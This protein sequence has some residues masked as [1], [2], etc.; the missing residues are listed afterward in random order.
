M[1]SGG[2][3]FHYDDSEWNQMTIP[4]D[5]EIQSI[6]G[7]SGSDVYAVGV[8]PSWGA[9][10]HYDGS[11]WSEMTIPAGIETLGDVWG[12]S[13]NDIFAVEIAVGGGA[14]LHYY[15]AP[16]DE[17][18]PAFSEGYPRAEKIIASG[19]DLKVKLDEPGTV[20]YKAVADGEDPGSDYAGWTAVDIPD[21][22]EVSA[23]IGGLA[24]DTAYDLYVIAKDEAG[25]MQVSPV[26]LD[27]STA[28]EPDTAPPA[29]S[30]GYPRVEKIIASG[31]DLKVKLDEPGIAYYKV[32]ASGAEPGTAYE[33]WTAVTV[34]ASDEVSTAVSGLT[35]GTAHDLYVIAK[36]E[37][38]NLQAAPVKLAIDPAPQL[39][40]GEA[41]RSALDAGI[42]EF[43]SDR[44]GSYYYAVVE[45]D[46]P[47]PNVDTSGAGTS[48]GTEK[49]VISLSGLNGAGAKDV[50]IAVK[51]GAA[52]SSTLKI[53]LP[54]YE[55]PADKTQLDAL[56][57][58]AE[59]LKS[60]DYTE[61]SWA[62]FTEAL[63]TARTVS[64]KEDATQTEV[65]NATAALSAAKEQLVM[66]G[67]EVKRTAGGNRYDT[68]AKTALDAYPNG[69]ETVIIARGDDQGNFA[70][71]LAASYLAGVKDAP[72]LLTSPG[73]LP[74]EIEAAINKLGATKAYVLGGELAVSQGVES[75]LKSLG[76]EVE[77][78]TGNNRY[79][80]A[81][82]IAAKGGP[83]DTAIVVSGFAPAD[84]L[85]A[86]SLAF[87]QGYPL[88]LVD[89]NSVPAETKNAIT[90]LGIKKIIV[91]GGENAV[92]KAVYNELGAKERYAGQS[93]IETSLDVAEKAF[94]DAKDFSIVGYLKL[95]D[96][97]GAAV[98]GN[99]II[100]VKD[101][102]SDVD[103]YL[104]GAV[105]ANSNFTIF[106][107][108]LA[109]SNTVE[110][111]LKELLK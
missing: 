38:G 26:K 66:L 97:V 68:S 51:A 86:G 88:L 7:T 62:G 64:A 87:S 94:K 10:L 27:V 34:P 55:E 100:Y 19:F 44:A 17:T 102:I 96:A 92:S 1:L 47:A 39:S 76:L 103:D 58:E 20:Y 23:A 53:T 6:W 45:A 54:A 93:R 36:D 74:Q 30:E 5:T 65:D 109:V 69:A 85:V 104:T 71:G 79:A 81:A 80:T 73:S 101:N 99:P 52:V 12:S 50:Y 91:I 14:I 8:G 18:P 49:T 108:T 95:A 82:A 21:S 40:A 72:V 107:G 37:A 16:P 28:A 35:P 25:N 111:E 110:D 77:R 75:K 4:A 43:T 32:V 2:V 98:N 84:S 56:I 83:A 59:Q 41:E 105:A 13:A 3:L 89:K 33:T 29:F 24:S 42:V 46:S 31:F 60:G 90:S 63:Q 48:C 70:D 106:G 9:I 15:K 61:E 67:G 57:A 22:G 11:A 78:I